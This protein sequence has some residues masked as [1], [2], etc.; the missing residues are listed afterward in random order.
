MV[1]ASQHEKVHLPSAEAAA[2]CDPVG[3]NVKRRLDIIVAATALV[4]LLPML[5]LVSLLVWATMGRPVLCR[6]TCVGFGGRLF[7]SYQFRTTAKSAGQPEDWQGAQSLSNNPAITPLGG[8]LRAS[9]ID[10]LPQLINILKGDMSCVGPRPL[11]PDEVQNY[12]GDAGPY[13]KARPGMTGVCQE[14]RHQTLGLDDKVALDST[15]VHNWSMQGDIILLL[16][17]IPAVARTD[18]RA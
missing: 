7:G 16:K 10:R 8:V 12:A 14:C 4:L 11:A 5:V 18:D 15:Y 13:L 2:A 9:G 6:R 17:A 1:F 3:G